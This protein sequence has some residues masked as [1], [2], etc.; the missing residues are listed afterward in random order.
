MTHITYRTRNLAD[1]I[2]ISAFGESYTTVKKE[3]LQKDAIISQKDAALSETKAALSQKD[4]V[5][6]KSIIGLFTNKSMTIS[7]I[8]ELLTLSPEY[9]SEVLATH[10]LLP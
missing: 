2:A 6:T 7:E 10:N 5:I 8:A 9:I 3:A 1:A 4:A